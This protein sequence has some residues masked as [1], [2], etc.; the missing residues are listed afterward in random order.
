MAIT[1]IDR[2]IHT[3]QE[4]YLKIAFIKVGCKALGNLIAILTLS[5]ILYLKKI[6]E[7]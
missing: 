5:H 4:K 7:A 1:A 2:T 6:D 3:F